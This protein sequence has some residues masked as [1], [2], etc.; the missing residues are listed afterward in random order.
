MKYAKAISKPYTTGNGGEKGL[1]RK[2]FYMY[3]LIF[4]QVFCHQYKQVVPA[5]FLFVL[6]F[7]CTEQLRQCLHLSNIGE[8]LVGV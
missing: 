5:S 7:N 6:T 8:E 4:S 1:V 3:A 2:G